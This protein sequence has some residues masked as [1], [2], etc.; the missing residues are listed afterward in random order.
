MLFL[1]VVQS[2]GHRDR[3]GVRQLLSAGDGALCTRGAPLKQVRG[4]RYR[5]MSVPVHI[6]SMTVCNCP[7]GAGGG[8]EGKENKR[9]RG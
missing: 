5:V 1:L 8:G 7:C 9:R 2:A 6:P 4:F 3:V